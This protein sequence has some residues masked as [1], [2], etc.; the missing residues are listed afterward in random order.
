M[1]SLLKFIILQAG[2]LPVIFIVLLSAGAGVPGADWR[3]YAKSEF[4]TYCFDTKNISR[5]SNHLVRVWQKLILNNKGTVNL[6]GE[7]GKEYENAREVIILRE[8][9]CINKK[10]RILELALSSEEGRVMKRETYDPLEWDS[11]VP[12]SV[13]DV[14]YCAICK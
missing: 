9:D 14:L 1:I 11:I 5:L 8:I 13:D 3:F 7:Y 2:V 4:G 10:S 12:D 6:A